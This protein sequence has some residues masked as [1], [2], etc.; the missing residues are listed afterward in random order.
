V[1][2]FEVGSDGL[3]VPLG[4]RDVP[5]RGCVDPSWSESAAPRDRY[6]VKIA[7]W[8][9]LLGQTLSFDTV[10][11][12]IARLPFE[13]T[14]G[15]L[16]VLAGALYH[17]RYETH[18]HWQLACDVLIE[19]PI[20]EAVRKFLAGGPGRI[21][22]DPRYLTAFQRLLV[23]HSSSDSDSLDE[24]QARIVIACLLAL[25]DVLPEA[26]AADS[27]AIVQAGADA[28]RLGAYHF[29]PL[30]PDSIVHASTMFVELVSAPDLKDRRNYCP[31]EDWSVDAYGATLADQIFY[32]FTLLHSARA[33]DPD[34]TLQQRAVRVPARHLDSIVSAE[35]SDRLARA[36]SATRE[37]FRGAF[38][39][40][41]QTDAHIAWDHT[42][43]E[44]QP[45]LRGE[46][47][48]LML[49]SP[50]ALQAWMTRGIYFRMMEAARG[51]EDAGATER[52]RIERF[53][54]FCGPL[55]ERYVLRLVE[56]S[57]EAHEPERPVNVSGEQRYRVDKSSVL[58]PDVAIAQPPDLVLVEV[59][60]GRI[61]RRA[62]VNPTPHEVDDTLKK[63]LIKKLGQLQKR[64]ADLL[65]ERF[66]PLG[67]CDVETLKVWPLIL[68]TGEGIALTPILWRWVE[69]SLPDGS[70]SDERV[71]PP[72]ICS[73]DE[74]EQLLVLVERGESLPE[75]LASFHSSGY[76]RLPILNWI[77]DTYTI[78]A[79]EI[80]TYVDEQY[81]TITS[82]W[83]ESL[84][85]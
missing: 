60:S 15:S 58:S 57:Y 48:S 30:L 7:S 34:A 10:L 28:L 8:E 65:A 40:S 3:W 25:P 56:R 43:F 21:V 12:C 1:R 36:I 62:R 81:T 79:D 11:E 23:E 38:S 41:G 13:A 68:L 42:P 71:G 14:M 37:E 2:G 78:E 16:S 35:R 17:A 39:A 32:G 46:D 27:N 47:G 80:A 44:Q 69:L 59:Y 82:R 84:N 9:A 77:A 4:S 49:L 53:T 24:K 31:L 6:E 54:S 72:T 74:F 29:L 22:F 26:S 67:V 18:K 5:D 85:A 45:F 75:L 33:L 55:A 61:P 52:S 64:V 51:R 20:L 73:L 70:F 19:G 83:R 66:T 76:A 50:R 63:M